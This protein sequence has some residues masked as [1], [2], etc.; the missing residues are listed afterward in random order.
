MPVFADLIYG[1]KHDVKA[2]HDIEILAGSIVVTNRAYVDFNWMRELNEQ[3]VFFVIRGKKNIKLELT[4]RDHPK[5]C[6]NENSKD[7]F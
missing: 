7:N 6:V 2:A 4:E 1:K 3:E 5:K